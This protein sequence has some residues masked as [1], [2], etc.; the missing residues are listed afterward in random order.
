MLRTSSRKTQPD[1]VA[2]VGGCSVYS[3]PILVQS[4]VTKNT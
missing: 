2:L 1:C 3:C 4:N